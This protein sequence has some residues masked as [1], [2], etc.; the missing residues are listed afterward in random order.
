VCDYLLYNYIVHSIS[1]LKIDTCVDYDFLACQ[2]SCS[3]LPLQCLQLLTYK[4][5]QGSDNCILC[6]EPAFRF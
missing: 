2:I 3:S 5:L 6:L 4:I 1:V